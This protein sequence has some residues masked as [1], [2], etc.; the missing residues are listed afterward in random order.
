VSR[1]KHFSAMPDG[2]AFPFFVFLEDNSFIPQGLQ[3]KVLRN[4]K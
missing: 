1:K 3:G 4:A 2:L